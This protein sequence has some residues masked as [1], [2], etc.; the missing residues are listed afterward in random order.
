MRSAVRWATVVVVAGLVATAA[1]PRAGYAQ[2]PAPPTDTVTYHL[3][4]RD[5]RRGH[6]R[7]G[8]RGGR[9]VPGL[10][11]FAFTDVNRA[12]LLHDFPE[13]TWEIIVE[14]L[15]Y[16][17]VEGAVTVAEGNG[18]SWRMTPNPGGAGRLRGPDAV[19]PVARRET[20]ALPL[21]GH[22]DLADDAGERRQ[23]GPH[24]HLPAQ[25]DVLHQR[26]PN[27]TR[28]RDRLDDTPTA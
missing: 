19:G 26:L 16:N 2:E 9:K 8:D 1:G 24:R 7:S 3:C 11:R 17:T 5:R 4:R 21:P 6:R 20:A 10:R 14:H 18:L 22:E 13:G 12:L 23:R 27:P 15:G 25:F 28:P